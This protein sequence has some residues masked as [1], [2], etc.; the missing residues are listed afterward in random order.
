MQVKK[1][2]EVNAISISTVKIVQTWKGHC[3]SEK[4]LPKSSFPRPHTPYVQQN[5]KGSF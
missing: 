2:R 3:G 1:K 5:H 4:N